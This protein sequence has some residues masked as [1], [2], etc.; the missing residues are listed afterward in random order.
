VKSCVGLSIAW[1]NFNP[2]RGELMGLVIDV[3]DRVSVELRRESFILYVEDERS[4]E[5]NYEDAEAVKTA[6]ATVVM[7]AR[8]LEHMGKPVKK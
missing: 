5:Y 8:Y 3:T 7:E 1:F 4:V 2:K 6:M